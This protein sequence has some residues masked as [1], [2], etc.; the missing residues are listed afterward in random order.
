MPHAAGGGPQV[1]TPPLFI[2]NVSGVEVLAN[3]DIQRAG[4]LALADGVSTADWLAA[5]PEI[6][7]V[8][9]DMLNAGNLAATVDVAELVA[10]RRHVT[11]IN[12]MQPNH[13]R[14]PVA[15]ASAPDLLVTPYLRAEDLRPPPRARRWLAG[16]FYAFLPLSYGEARLQPFPDEPRILVACGGADPSGLWVHIASRLAEGHAGRH[17]CWPSIRPDPCRSS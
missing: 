12:S 7:A 16:A 6:A 1:S 15:P 11:V 9:V 3:I 17:C 4:I 13:F 5:N 2:T 8:V 14:D 10:S